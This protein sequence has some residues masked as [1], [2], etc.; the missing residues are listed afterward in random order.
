MAAPD[1]SKT[2]EG[3]LGGL[4]LV[5]TDGLNTN[6]AVNFSGWQVTT[7]G[8][9]SGDVTGPTG[10]FA[11]VNVQQTIIAGSTGSAAII[12]TAGASGGGP[13]TPNAQG[14]VVVYVSGV[15]C[16]IPVWQ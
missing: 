4:P 15:K 13:T 8:L 14:W 1:A 12:A 6:Q 3:A 2:L 10:S 16:W 7:G 11:N 9:A 5:A